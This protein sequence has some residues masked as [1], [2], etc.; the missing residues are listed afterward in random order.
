MMS[1]GFKS[2]YLA[3]GLVWASWH[4]PLIAFGNFYQTDNALLMAF[5]YGSHHRHELFHQR[6]Q[7]ALGSVW[8]AAIAHAS[9]NFFFQLLVPVL[10]LTVP[11][12]HSELWDMLAS[13][14]GLCIAVLY[15][16][17]YL[18]SRQFLRPTAPV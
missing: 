16:V 9:H 15:A 3:C 14:T 2:P 8:V 10:L 13:D 12:S 6:T 11:G 4:I 17:T 7:G 18:A 1:G 5:I